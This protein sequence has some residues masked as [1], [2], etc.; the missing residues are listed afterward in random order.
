MWILTFLT[1]AEWQRQCFSAHPATS[2]LWL[3]FS[4]FVLCLYS[5]QSAD[6]WE[7]KIHLYCCLL[8]IFLP[9]PKVGKKKC[10]KPL[11]P[12]IFIWSHVLPK[13][14]PIQ[15]LLLLHTALKYFIRPEV[16]L[17]N[18]SQVRWGILTHLDHTTS[19]VG[20]LQG[21]GAWS[22]ATSTQDAREAHYSSD[23]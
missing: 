14:K 12:N 22:A 20:G 7:A 13:S 8:L 18:V 2:I 5:S 1:I 6:D 19:F 11:I 17:L 15:Y 3:L 21:T 23:S 16:L 9:P 4:C 10:N